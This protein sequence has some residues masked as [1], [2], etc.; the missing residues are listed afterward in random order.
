MI[1]SFYQTNLASHAAPW[2]LRDG[3]VIASADRVQGSSVLLTSIRLDGGP[4]ASAPIW[5]ARCKPHA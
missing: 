4:T 2:I 3:P 5:A 1:E